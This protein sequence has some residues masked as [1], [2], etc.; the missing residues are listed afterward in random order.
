MHADYWID[1]QEG[2]DGKVYHD[3]LQEKDLSHNNEETRRKV[4][5]ALRPTM[6]E[7]IRIERCLANYFD[8]QSRRYESIFEHTL[9]GVLEKIYSCLGNSNENNNE[10]TIR[11]EINGDWWIHWIARIGMERHFLQHNSYEEYVGSSPSGDGTSFRTEFLTYSC[12]TIPKRE[13]SFSDAFFDLLNKYKSM[14]ESR[15]LMLKPLPKLRTRQD[16]LALSSSNSDAS[17]AN[18]R[19]REGK[20]RQR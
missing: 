7:L 2:D 9:N 20:K 15:G 18:A 5:L 16:G 6:E 17:K 4:P 12:T 19:P 8:N 1:R 13:L 10:D 14:R 3:L 11:R